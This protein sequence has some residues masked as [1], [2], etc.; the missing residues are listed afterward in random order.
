MGGMIA[1]SLAARHPASL[2]RLVLAATAPGDGHATAPDAAL[3]GA[4]SSGNLLAGSGALDT[5][6][7]PGQEAAA[8][9]FA[10]QI[11]RYP[12]AAPAAPRAITQQQFAASGTWI[13]GSEPSGRALG[14]L[15][16]PVLVG[17]GTLDR[18]LPFANDQH[19]AQAVRGARLVTYEGAAHGFLYQ[20]ADRF[21]PEV[22]GFLG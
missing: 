22:L 12:N 15:R 18:L 7:P 10:Q 20:D 16:L 6:F 4:L 19:I 2:R 13:L 11:A 14:R 1:Q 3:L 9:R 17:G 5:I 21:V 8:Q